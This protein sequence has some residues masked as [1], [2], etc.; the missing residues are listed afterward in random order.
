[1]GGKDSQIERSKETRET[2]DTCWK[3]IIWEAEE[4]LYSVV[5]NNWRVQNI[6]D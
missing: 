6:V 3:K 1:M 5:E 2:D 4:G